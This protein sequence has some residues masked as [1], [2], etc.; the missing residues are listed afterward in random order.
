MD[1]MDKKRVMFC[2]CVLI[3]IFVS[4]SVIF[5]ASFDCGKAASKIE[6]LI[7]SDDELSKL[8]ES[9]NEVYLRALNRAD[10]K[11]QAIESQRQWLKYE[12]DVCQDAECIKKAYET[13]IKE[14]G[15]TSSFPKAPVKIPESEVVQPSEKMTQTQTEQQSDISAQD[16]K[17]FIKGCP[18]PILPDYPPPIRR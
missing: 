5:A 8:D 7:C 12:R 18:E 10:I 6:K 11:E 9:L 4:P 15:F 13:R 1:L 17:L 14:L 2:L 16:D 3:A